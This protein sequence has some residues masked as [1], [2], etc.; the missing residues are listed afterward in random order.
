MKVFLWV[1]IGRMLSIEFTLVIRRILDLVCAMGLRKLAT[2]IAFFA[3]RA[4]WCAVF[5][6]DLDAA[7]F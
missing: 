1:S 4:L 6:L 5:L 3:M 7:A 2:R